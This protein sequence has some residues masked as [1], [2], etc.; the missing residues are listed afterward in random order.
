ME[1][2]RR[3]QRSHPHRRQPHSGDSR[4]Q[5]R[6]LIEGCS[7]AGTESYEG[8]RELGNHACLHRGAKSGIPRMHVKVGIPEWNTTME[9][10][11]QEQEGMSHECASKVQNLLEMTPEWWSQCQVRM[12]WAPLEQQSER[13][14]ESVLC[15]RIEQTRR[16]DTVNNR[17]TSAREVE[18]DILKLANHIREQCF[19]QAETFISGNIRYQ[20]FEDQDGL[21]KGMITIRRRGVEAFE[22]DIALGCLLGFYVGNGIQANSGRVYKWCPFWGK[23]GITTARVTSITR[24]NDYYS[25]SRITVTFDSQISGPEGIYGAWLLLFVSARTNKRHHH[26]HQ[27]CSVVAPSLHATFHAPLLLPLLLSHNIPLPRVH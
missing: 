5:V 26:H 16:E 6:K 12:R 13:E 24:A 3:G 21:G 23:M 1:S 7:I 14:R 20:G 17:Q 10:W 8:R 15:I 11:M 25:K 22:I 9:K 18:E 19:Q 27:G 2:E 4:E